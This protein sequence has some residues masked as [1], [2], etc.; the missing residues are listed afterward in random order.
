MKFISYDNCIIRNKDFQRYENFLDYRWN[1]C[2]S[3]IHCNNVKSWIWTELLVFL[4]SLTLFVVGIE[5]ISMGFM[6]NMTKSS[7]ISNIVLDALT[8]GL[9]IVVIA[10]P[11]L[12]WDFW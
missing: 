7:R 1:Y 4:L 11:I 6:P 5:R 2:Y 3:F 12:Q 8:I 10:F 9:A